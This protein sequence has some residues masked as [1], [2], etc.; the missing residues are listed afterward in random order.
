M[1][2][3]SFLIV[4][5][6]KSGTTS[7][8]YELNSN[9]EIGFPSL[10]EPKFFSSLNLKFPHCGPGDVSVDKYAVT[11]I[12]EYK[13]L[14]E[15]INGK[16]IGEISPDY[17]FYHESTIPNI[18]AIL[19]DI[20]IVIILRNPVDR[21]YSAYTYL[22]RDSRE[23]ES[24]EMALKIEK[25]RLSKN[26]DFIWGYVACSEYYKQV[27]AYMDAFS[28]V[29]V[30]IL[31]E[32]I[33]DKESTL[34]S[35]SKFIGAE[36]CKINLERKK[37]NASGI[38]TNIFA[39]FVLSRNNSFSLWLR[40]LLKKTIKRELLEK[41]SQ[42]FMKKNNMDLATRLYLQDYFREDIKKMEVLLGRDLS[43]WS[44]QTSNGK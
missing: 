27:K 25:D 14:F 6:A 30:I 5:A 1:S 7:L 22:V 26:Y 40:W 8:Y 32:Y 3:P 35:L 9:P 39:S 16:V 29:K 24:F 43:I 15:N 4:G 2:L 12:S 23:T 37:Y 20:P 42:R 11:N 36:K 38:P 41:V 34:E 13:S 10:K 19:G 31:E 21:A 17:L 28:K 33:I 18:K 44:D